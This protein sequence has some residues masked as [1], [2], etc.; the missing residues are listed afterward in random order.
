MYS[1]VKTTVS[2]KD[3]PPYDP[4]KETLEWNLQTFTFV[5][6]MIVQA[7]A[8][9]LSIAALSTSTESNSKPELL[10]TILVLELV[11][12]SVE[13]V[14][15][16]VVGIVFYFGKVSIGVQYRYLDW[17]VT[18]PTMLISILLFIWYLQCDIYTLENIG[19]SNGKMV[20]ILIS[21]LL[22]WL[23]LGMGFTHE[24]RM[25]SFTDWVDYL[26]CGKNSILYISFLPFVGSYVPIFYYAFVD[27]NMIGIITVLVTFVIWTLYGVAA[28]LYADEKDDAMKNTWYNVLDIV[29]KNIAGITISI[30]AFM[31]EPT[32]VDASAPLCNAT[33][34]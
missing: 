16:A 3:Y 2:K 30:V 4:P 19:E 24:A 26:F 18:T 29:S 8:L 27:P 12:Q 33:S 22:N 31:Y 25:K 1:V 5:I 32:S 6:S 21:V 28:I 20:A 15:Y 13:L 10:V 23:M 17:M 9:G 14:W 7:V 34:A 11:V